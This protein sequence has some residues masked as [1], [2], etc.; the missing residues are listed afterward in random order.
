MKT[1]QTP[2]EQLLA[3]KEK[4]RQQVKV[5]EDKLNANFKYLHDN[6]GKLVIN[7]ITSA[8]LPHKSPK[9]NQS[10]SSSRPSSLTDIAVGGV[11]SYLK[12]NKGIFP[13]IWNVAQPFLFTWGIKGAKKVIRNLFSRKKK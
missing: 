13:M 1:N 9:P 3:K 10:A 6:A 4:V 8:I 11:S 2:L 5:Q 12:G 7:S